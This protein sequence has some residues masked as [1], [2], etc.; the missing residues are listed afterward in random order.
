MNSN[1]NTIAIVAVTLVLTGCVTQPRGPDP[2]QPGA[3]IS[4]RSADVKHVDLDV[5]GHGAAVGKNFLLGTA[6]GAAMGAAGGA[7]LGF[8]CGPL[9]LFC[10]PIF[11]V[12]GAGAGGIV[13]AVAGTAH[14][15]RTG[16][17]AEKAKQFN[18]VVAETINEAMLHQQLHQRFVDQAR[19][20]W[21][22]V[23]GDATNIVSLKITALRFEQVRDDELKLVMSATAR[24][25]SG[26]RTKVWGFN[27]DSAQHHVD[28]WL[29]DDGALFRQEVDAG[30]DQLT[31]NMVMALYQLGTTGYATGARQGAFSIFAS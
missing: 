10:A 6:G 2:L 24:V 4:I 17:P 5:D 11:A 29:S 30:M 31:R 23:D 22:V 15:A 19:A 13:G 28:T 7:A 18:T 21:T 8:A 25:K 20:Y 9:V 16:L 1:L 3:T 12:A 14:G 27:F 26:R